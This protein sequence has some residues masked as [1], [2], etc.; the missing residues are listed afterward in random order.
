MEPRELKRQCANLDIDFFV[1][2]ETQSST[3]KWPAI[4]CD[5]CGEMTTCNHKLYTWQ[6]WGWRAPHFVK[7]CMDCGKKTP[8]Y[9]QK[10]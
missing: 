2:R 4:A 9:R 8:L 3:V 7:R 1:D 5:D 6:T 10:I